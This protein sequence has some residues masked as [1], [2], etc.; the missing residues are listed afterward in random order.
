M[1]IKFKIWVYGKLGYLF[2][3]TA[4]KLWTIE[5]WYWNAYRIGEEFDDDFWLQKVCEWLYDVGA[6]FYQ[7]ETDLEK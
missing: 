4:F 6:K 3:E 7:K 2:C 1:M 5:E